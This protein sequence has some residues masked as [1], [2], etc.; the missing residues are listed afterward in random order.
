MEILRI[1]NEPLI[2]GLAGIA[3]ALVLIVLAAIRWKGEPDDDASGGAG[4]D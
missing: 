4:L 1:L 3:G 2:R